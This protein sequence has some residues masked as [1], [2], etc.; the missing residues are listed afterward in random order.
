MKGGI[1][2]VEHKSVPSYKVSVFK[3]KS[4]ADLDSDT[5]TRI[6]YLTGAKT[7]GVS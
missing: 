6:L 7:V 1:K 4:L 2:P 3:F 5:L